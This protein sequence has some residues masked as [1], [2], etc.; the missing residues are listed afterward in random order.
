MRWDVFIKLTRGGLGIVNT[1]YQFD[2]AEKSVTLVKQVSGCFQRQL[3]HDSS[4]LGNPITG[5]WWTV[6]DGCLVKGSSSLEA[7]CLVTSCP[8]WFLAVMNTSVPSHHDILTPAE[9]KLTLE[10][11]SWNHEPKWILSPTCVRHLSWCQN[12]TNTDPPWK[13]C[14]FILLSSWHNLES[15]GKE[16]TERKT[17]LH[18]T[19]LWDTALTANCGEY[20][21]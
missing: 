14:W 15:L 13:L 3:H 6:E 5:C 8:L 7:R 20:N 18:W 17:C 4:K 11:T 10:E 12:L 19:C 21:P 16:E 1:I 2:W 9:P